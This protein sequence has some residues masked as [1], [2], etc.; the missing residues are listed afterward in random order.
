VIGG[1]RHTTLGKLF[2]PADAADVEDDAV[3]GV[4]H[5]GT[6]AGRRRQQQL[7]PTSSAAYREKQH[8][9]GR[10]ITP[11]SSPAATLRSGVSVRVS[12]SR[13]ERPKLYRLVEFAARPT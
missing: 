9:R 4:G 8:R 10:S 6:E 12:S 1:T 13:D 2:T 5:D 7:D 11:A 3:L